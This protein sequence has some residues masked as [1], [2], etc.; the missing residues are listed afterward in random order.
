MCQDSQGRYWIQEGCI[1]CLARGE[2]AW[3]SGHML[4]GEVNFE[5]E[6]SGRGF[7]VE[8]KERSGGIKG[9][10]DGGVGHGR[11]R[12]DRREGVTFRSKILGMFAMGLEG[13]GCG[14]G[15]SAMLMRGGTL[16]DVGG[17]GIGCLGCV[18]DVLVKDILIWTQW[19][20]VGVRTS[21]RICCELKRE[22]R[23]WWLHYI[24]EKEVVAV[25]IVR[26]SSMFGGS[27]AFRRIWE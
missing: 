16:S 27:R 3:K 26:K 22:L 1:E 23:R 24:C 15:L 6:R 7:F 12:R 9:A 17:R 14:W 10:T 18:K 21:G 13:M 25:G 8:G 4:E 20:Y 11:V 5:G 2:G 19:V